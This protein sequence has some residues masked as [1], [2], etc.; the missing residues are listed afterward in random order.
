MCTFSVAVSV[1]QKCLSARNLF[2]TLPETNVGRRATR[3][4]LRK[5]LEQQYVERL[6]MLILGSTPLVYAVAPPGGTMHAIFLP[7]FPEDFA[8]PKS[9]TR[10]SLSQNMIQEVL[11]SSMEC[12]V[13]KNKL[14]PEMEEELKGSVPVRPQ[15]E[16]DAHAH[17]VKG[18]QK[19]KASESARREKA[20][21]AVRQAATDVL[22]DCN[23]PLSIGYMQMLGR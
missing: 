19:R 7:N 8:V 15:T 12:L 14:T 1:I 13:R 5:G 22:P 16:I 21:R 6:K 17:A 20:V 3:G 9:L 2:L 23:T 11:R 18:L 10:T 4:C